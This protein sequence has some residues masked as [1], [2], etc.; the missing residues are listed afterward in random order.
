MLW[1]L[2]TNSDSSVTYIYDFTRILPWDPRRSDLFGQLQPF[3]TAAATQR[4]EQASREAAFEPE[5]RV[6]SLFS[7]VLRP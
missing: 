1:A 6:E 4:F 5:G 7:T 2:A 3:L